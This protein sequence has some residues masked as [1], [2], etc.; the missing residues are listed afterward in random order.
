[1][2]KQFICASSP[3]SRH[4]K[5]L[6]LRMSQKRASSDPKFIPPQIGEILKEYFRQFSLDPQPIPIPITIT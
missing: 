5:L 3:A 4:D 2:S 1:M 6:L